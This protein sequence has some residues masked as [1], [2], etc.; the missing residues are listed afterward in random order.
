M[1]TL[2]KT[3]NR[4]PIPNVLEKGGEPGISVVLALD[5]HGPEDIVVDVNRTCNTPA[6]DAEMATRERG[7]AISKKLPNPSRPNIATPNL[8]PGTNK[9]FRPGGVNENGSS[10]AVLAHRVWL[11]ARDGQ[12]RRSNKLDVVSKAKFEAQILRQIARLQQKYAGCTVV[13]DS[14]CRTRARH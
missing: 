14:P 12:E 1:A 2:D 3:T 9:W 8:L 5:V 4:P 6:D 11:C 7:L 10:P 13:A